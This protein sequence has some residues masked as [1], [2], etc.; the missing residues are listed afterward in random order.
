MD[1]PGM[2]LVQMYRRHRLLNKKKGTNDVKVW[3][4]PPQRRDYTAKAKQSTYFGYKT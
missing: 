2:N 4:T 3:A 1:A